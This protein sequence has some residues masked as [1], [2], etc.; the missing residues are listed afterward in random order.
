MSLMAGVSS[1]RRMKIRM[2]INFLK[3]INELLVSYKNKNKKKGNRVHLMI[4]RN[5]RN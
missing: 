4:S 1:E 3:R 5:P 2:L